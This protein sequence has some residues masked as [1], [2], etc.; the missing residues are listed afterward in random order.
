MKTIKF[1]LIAVL[2]LVISNLSV[3]AS[4]NDELETVKFSSLNAS[5]YKQ[6]NRLVVTLVNT[7]MQKIKLV[8][9]DQ[10]GKTVFSKAMS[11][12]AFSTKTIKVSKLKAGK[13]TAEI[14]SSNQTIKRTIQI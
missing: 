8:L 6:D 2:F 11:Q 4:N 14:S 10:F 9:K 7:D 5:V 12:K 13:Y 3:L 1:T